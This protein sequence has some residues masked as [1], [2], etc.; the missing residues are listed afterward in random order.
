MM[1]CHRRKDVASLGELL[2]K[3]L[4]AQNENPKIKIPGLTQAL[5]K[6]CNEN[7]LELEEKQ[8]LHRNYLPE[9]GFYKGA[10]EYWLDRLG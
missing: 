6:V 5:L 1:K 7:K 4:D 10:L 3:Q 8:L 9:V 2:D